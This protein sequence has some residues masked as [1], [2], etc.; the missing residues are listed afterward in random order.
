MHYHIKAYHASIVQYY[1][2]TT[3]FYS[4]GVIIPWHCCN[5]IRLYQQASARANAHASAHA[6][7][8]VSATANSCASAC[9]GANSPCAV[10]HYASSP[11]TRFQNKFIRFTSC[12]WCTTLSVCQQKLHCE[13]L[14]RKITRSTAA[15]RETLLQ[16]GLFHNELKGTC[17]EQFPYCFS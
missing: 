16:P 3:L 7:I 15:H 13:P 9:A 12:W 4:R 11:K 1:T 10:H 17:R 6:I 8:S 5:I 2:T 14:S